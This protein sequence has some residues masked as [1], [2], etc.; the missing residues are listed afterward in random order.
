[1]VEAVLP[2]DHVILLSLQRLADSN[3]SSQARARYKEEEELV[4]VKSLACHLFQCYSYPFH[5]VCE[6]SS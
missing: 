5:L 6:L 4:K 3:M 1:M 2:A